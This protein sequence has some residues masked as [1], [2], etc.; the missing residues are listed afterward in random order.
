MRFVSSTVTF[1]H[2]FHCVKIQVERNSNV[3]Q[4]AGFYLLGKAC[5]N[6]TCKAIQGEGA[7]GR[8]RQRHVYLFWVIKVT[9]GY[10]FI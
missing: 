9:I 10:H 2:G 4:S 8:Y 3:S 7:L 6:T 1:E 5:L